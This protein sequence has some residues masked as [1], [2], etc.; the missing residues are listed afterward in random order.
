MRLALIDIDGVIADPS[1]RI[2]KAE[3]A[4]KQEEDCLYAEWYKQNNGR[5]ISLERGAEFELAVKKPLDTVYW[6]TAFTPELVTL[7][8][9]IKDARG[10]I[11]VVEDGGYKV[12][13]LTLRPESLREAT[14]NWFKQHGFN[15]LSEDLIMKPASQQ[16]V[17]TV[18]WKSGAVELLVRLF[19]VDEL[20]FIDDKEVTQEAIAALNL[21]CDL[22]IGGSLAE[23]LAMLEEK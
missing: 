18:T 20:F 9:L 22:K 4:R 15:V 16:Y 17:K 21:P 3:E 1:A 12:Y 2:A 5:L 7:D 19:G 11:W 10:N 13:Y 6:R 14:L 8:T 23:A